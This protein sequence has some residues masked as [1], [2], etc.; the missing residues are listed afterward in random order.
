MLVTQFHSVT[1]IDMQA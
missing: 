1:F